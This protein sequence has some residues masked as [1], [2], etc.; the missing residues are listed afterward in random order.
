MLPKSRIASIIVLGLGVA[1][2]VAG[3]LA[4]RFIHTDARLPLDLEQSTWTLVDEDGKAQALTADGPQ[5]YEGPLTLRNHV[6]IQNPAD[7]DTATLRIGRTLMKGAAEGGEGDA[8]QDGA[9]GSVD[10]LINAAIWTY[11]IDRLTGLAQAP[12]RLSNTLAVPAVDVDVAG[13][14]WKF[15]ADAQRTNYPVFDP[16]LRQARDAVFVEATE[17]QGRS[18]YHYRQDIEPVNVATLYAGQGN[19][20]TLPTPDGGTQPGYLFHSAQRDFYVDQMTGL[21]VDLDVKIDDYYGDRD[22]NRHT[23]VL[24]FEA[25]LSADD[26]QAFV[27]AASNMPNPK[28]A[29]LIR[30]IIVGAGAVLALLSLVG[31]FG[32]F[33]R[34]RGGG[35][36]QSGA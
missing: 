30:W 33:G 20:S 25:G 28:T 11:P 23:D 9:S 16:T 17:I 7:A 36:R 1:M 6:D 8:G 10:D 21:I 32:G 12:A 19:T 14:W 4:P 2:I 26:S 15:P 24:D 31:V 29:N 3:L 35:H 34:R 18:V 22:G 13:Q 27:T 5:P